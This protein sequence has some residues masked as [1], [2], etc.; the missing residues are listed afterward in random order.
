MVQAVVAG[1]RDPT[2]FAGHNLLSTLTGNTMYT[3][4]TGVFA[5]G[6]GGSNQAFTQAQAILALAGAGNAGFPVPSAAVTELKSLR[7][8]AGATKG[9][10]QAFGTFDSNTTSM[11]LMALNSAGDTAANDS[12]LYTDAFG[13]LL[14]QQD[15]ASGGF[16]FST[17]FGSTSD[18]D[19]DALVIQG[20]TA[21]GQDP[22]GASWSNAKGNAVTDILTFQDAASGGF[23][24]SQG[25]KL[26]N[27]AT[28]QVAAG[29]RQA[30]F[31]IT[32]KFTAGAALPAAGCP[33]TAAQA[34]PAASAPGLPSAGAGTATGAGVV[35]PLAAM[36]A[37]IMV[38][39]LTRIAL[40]RR[41]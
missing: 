36:G 17:D 7:S 2:D 25:G 10:W 12:A 1:H 19:S 13:Y 31:P 27:F 14:T 33:A 11:A 18:P 38:V 40:G 8:T 41:R 34:L 6:A 39:G 26:Q 32:G 5:D 24:F 20:L 21:A 22:A 16:T 4:G 29:I 15:P 30:A 23:A 3:G 37:L 9:G 35:V 28:S